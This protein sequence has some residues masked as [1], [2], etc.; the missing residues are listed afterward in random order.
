MTKPSMNLRDVCPEG[1]AD[2][3]ELLM[4]LV[5]LQQFLA[6][7]A[8]HRHMVARVR[9]SMRRDNKQSSRS[10]VRLALADLKG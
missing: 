5:P 6:Q 7:S 10:L 2:C 3:R 9:L 1:Y 8:S 4:T